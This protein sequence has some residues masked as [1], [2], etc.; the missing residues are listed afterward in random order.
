MRRF[1]CLLTVLIFQCLAVSGARAA[2]D[3]EIING[4]NLTVFGAEYSP[5]GYQT[6]YVRKFGGPVR[7]YIHNLSS[8]NRTRDVKAFIQ[9]LNRS[10]RGLSTSVVQSPGQANFNVYIVD[11]KDYIDTVRQKIYKN[12]NA[13]TPGRCLVRAVFSRMGIRKAD[14]VI[15]ADEG[16]ALFDRCKAEEILQGLGPLNEHTSLRESM[17]NDRTRHTSFTHFDRM[18]LNMLYDPRIRNGATKE[19][20]QALLPVILRDAKARR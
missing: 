6:N 15:V 13:A 4:F 10:I 12:A 9:S 2:S 17:F 8:R 14:A 11:R 19:S 3:A 5:F 18:I 16:E 20:V 7:F 1:I